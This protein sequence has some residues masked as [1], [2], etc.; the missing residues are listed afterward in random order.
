MPSSIS[1]S[2]S[3]E[4][5]QR[6]PSSIRPGT[7]PDRQTRQGTH[8]SPRRPPRLTPAHR[9]LTSPFSCR[10][11]QH[12]AGAGGGSLLCVCGLHPSIHPPPNSLVRL[13]LLLPYMTTALAIA[14][15]A[16]IT[17]RTS[18]APRPPP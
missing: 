2:W 14:L 12:V 1:L 15:P 8:D 18:S 16:C 6:R 13:V 11:W 5:F 3:D 9:L 17:H 4:R 7:Q 10:P